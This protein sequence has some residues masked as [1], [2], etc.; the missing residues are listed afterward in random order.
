MREVVHTAV[1]AAR[2]QAERKSLALD[3]AAPAKP[4]Y[5]HGDAERLAQI[6]DN[7][8]RNAITYTDAGSV[9]VLLESAPPLARVTVRDTGVGIDPQQ[10]ELLFGPYQMRPGMRGGGLGLG[11]PL[12]K[13]LT[14]AHG[15]TV[16]FSSDGPGSGS[17]FTFTV[18]LSHASPGTTAPLVVDRPPRRRV[19]VVDDEKDVADMLGL[20]LGDL[21]Q[22]VTVAYSGPTAL[23][24]AKAVRPQVAFIDISMPRMDGRELARRLQQLFPASGI[25][26]VSITGASTTIEQAPELFAH[27]LLKPATVED[28]VRVLNTVPEQADQTGTGT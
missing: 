17:A 22:E 12:V 24:M 2:S 11:L 3:Y 28:L 16:S 18:P 23:E 4:I 27:Y 7:L 9:T 10:G 15:G 1:E 8:L 25:V 20:L 13:A 19:L 6:L 14:E 21:G 5:V 26:L